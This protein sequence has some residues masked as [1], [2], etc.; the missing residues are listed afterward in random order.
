MAALGELN[1][2]HQRQNQASAWI[3]AN[4][5]RFVKLTAER[6]FDYW[7]PQRRSVPLAAVELLITLA[8]LFG[9]GLMI[10]QQKPVAVVFLVIWM[11]QPLVYYV[12]QADERYRYPIEW[13]IVMCA[14]YA[15]VSSLRTWKG[16]A[17][18]DQR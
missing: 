10:R 16:V 9:L 6:F 3:R 2:Y 18:E 17:F 13:S 15:A 4:P 12:I 7:V 14:A 8:A 5:G 11:F 1:Y